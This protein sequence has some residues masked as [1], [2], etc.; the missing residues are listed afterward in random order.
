MKKEVTPEAVWEALNRDP[1]FAPK[2]DVEKSAF[3]PYVEKLPVIL[4]TMLDKKVNLKNM[5]SARY[6][7]SQYIMKNGFLD[8]AIKAAIEL[9]EEMPFSFFDK[10]DIENMLKQSMKATEGMMKKIISNMPAFL[11]EFGLTERDYM[12]GQVG[13]NKKTLKAYKAGTLTIGELLLEQP[14][15]IVGLQ[16]AQ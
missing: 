1:L 15:I 5:A 6:A 2:E 13:F 8:A 12:I 11:K 10:E 3:K 7:Y 14:G 4:K 16:P 9:I